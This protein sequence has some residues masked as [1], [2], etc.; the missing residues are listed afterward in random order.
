MDLIP[1]SVV[2]YVF[3]LFDVILKYQQMVNLT[4]NCAINTFISWWKK[5][6][7][8][9]IVLHLLFHS[10]YFSYDY[11]RLIH[12]YLHSRGD[13]S[14]ICF[15]ACGVFLI[16]AYFP[17]ILCSSRIIKSFFLLMLILRMF[18]DNRISYFIDNI[19]RITNYYKESRFRWPNCLESMVRSE[20]RHTWFL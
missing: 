2:F 9:S 16:I 13:M 4:W 20:L 1:D 5:L 14:F 11:I 12:S 6:F 7:F 18:K 3:Y 8:H 19:S 17:W 15:S 10:P